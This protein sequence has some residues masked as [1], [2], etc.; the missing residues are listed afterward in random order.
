MALSPFVLS[1]HLVPQHLL[2]RA[3]GLVADSHAAAIRDPFIKWFIER[4]GVDMKEAADPDPR[5]YSS[6]NEFFTRALKPD[7]RPLEGDEKT[8]ISPADGTISQLGEIRRGRIFQ[9][10][11]QSFSLAELTAEPE[12][13][14]SAFEGGAFSTIYLSPRDYHRVHMPLGGVLE[15]MTFI[16]GRLFSVNPKTTEEV[17][18][19]FAR[20]E[21]VVAWFRTDFGPMAVV[22]V[23]AMIVASIET[24]WAG[25]VAPA[26]N[27]LAMENYQGTNQHLSLARGEEMGR[28]RLGSTVILALPRD[29]LRWRS[30]Q[31]PG[32]TVR[33]GQA[34][35][36]RV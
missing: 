4:Y 1:Q 10:K 9:A 5:S 11:G 27:R 24:V 17:P 28:F 29:T 15:K 34:M 33:M 6:F 14:L 13:R 3:A 16:P 22:L 12:N 2:S 32:E 20:N 8:L 7:A 36:D 18:R 26:G 23:G 19:L 31:G 30:G 35:G 21:R 25:R